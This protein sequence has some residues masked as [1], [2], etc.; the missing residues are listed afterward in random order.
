MRK[1]IDRWVLA[2]SLL[3]AAPALHAV[4]ADPT[5]FRYTQPDG[6]VITL[7]MHGDEWFGWA[8]DLSGTVLA[9]EKDGFYRAVANPEAWLAARREEGV[10]MRRMA[11]QFRAEARRSSAAGRSPMTEGTRRIPVVLL[12]FSD[13]TFK[14]NNPA[15]AFDRMLNEE[16]YSANGAIGS[17]RDFYRDNSHEKF[18]PVFDVYGPVNINKPHAQYGENAG[19]EKA[20]IAFNLAVSM[21]DNE[22][23]FRNYDYDN[24]GTVDMILFYYAGHNTAEGGGYDKIWPHQWWFQYAGINQKY[25]GKS[26]GRYFCT[27]ELKG[28]YGTTMCSIGTTCHEFGHSLGLPDFYDTDYDTNG[29]AGGLYSF[30]TMCSG[31]YNSNSTKP[32]YFNVMERSLLGWCD[33]PEEIV[34]SGDYSLRSVRVADEAY[35]ISTATDGE[36]MIFECRDQNKW[37]APL[38]TGMVVYHLDRSRRS[39]R[40]YRTPYEQWYNWETY[41]SINAYGSH[42]CFYVIPAATTNA[43]F[44]NQYTTQALNYG[45]SENNMVFPGTSGKTQFAPVDWDKSEVD[46]LVSDIRYSGGTLSFHVRSNSYCTVGGFIGNTEGAPVSGAT[47]RWGPFETQSGADGRYQLIIEDAY[48]GQT[49]PIE[50]TCD[51]YEPLSRDFMPTQGAVVSMDFTLEI[52]LTSTIEYYGYNNFGGFVVGQIFRSGDVI[53]LSV[54]EAI[55]DARKPESVKWMYDGDFVKSDSVTLNSGRHSLAMHLTFSDGTTEIVE[56]EFV[57]L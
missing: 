53:A 57:V 47:V 29:S 51:G 6:S 50:V 5:P 10:R 8:S 42:P 36:I 56:Y 35:F 22:I 38:P 2:A 37:D 48:W 20:A 12:E 52:D 33:E 24:D 21:L 16:G 27:S 44:Q 41:N 17:V 49:K 31:S 1:A 14:I 55:P 32:P 11:D 30:S 54:S 19:T 45:G 25:D 28:Y 13:L 9:L 40:V 3:C 34:E 23:D 18:N 15:E 7:Q 26:L 39:G 43:R 46:F 4:P